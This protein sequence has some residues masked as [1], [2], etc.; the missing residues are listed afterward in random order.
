MVDF[1]G[2][3]L[4]PNFREK[5]KRYKATITGL[6]QTIE[7]LKVDIDVAN[8]TIDKLLKDIKEL[9]EELTGVRSRF[10]NFKAQTKAPNRLGKEQPDADLRPDD[11]VQ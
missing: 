7:G 11:D 8:S 5:E 6:G 10:R 2:T 1:E 9:K 4:Q 3:V